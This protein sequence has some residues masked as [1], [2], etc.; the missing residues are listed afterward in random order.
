MNPHIVYG[1]TKIWA[2]QRILLK[3]S[4]SGR[5]VNN[6]SA[7]TSYIRQC[8]VGVNET[9]VVDKRSEARKSEGRACKRSEASNSAVVAGKTS[10]LK[11]EGP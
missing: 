7:S 5:V 8:L 2:N 1:I 11:R 9:V 3:K 6:P 10:T 4:A